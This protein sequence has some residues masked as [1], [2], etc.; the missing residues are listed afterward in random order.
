M[1]PMTR[2]GMLPIVDGVDFLGRVMSSPPNHTPALEAA[3]G[4]P[5]QKDSE[6][7]SKTKLP[8]AIVE[9]AEDAIQNATVD[10]YVFSPPG[11]GMS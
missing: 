3:G 7:P 2:S 1:D 8:N 6:L 11:M 9:G 5:P 4:S 10:P